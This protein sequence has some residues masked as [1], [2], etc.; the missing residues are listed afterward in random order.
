MQGIN[1]KI[2]L[3]DMSTSSICVR[4]CITSVSQ[5]CLNESL[6]ELLQSS[7][8]KTSVHGYYYTMTVQCHCILMKTGSLQVYEGESA[9][10]LFC[11]P[12]N[13]KDF[14]TISHIMFMFIVANIHYHQ[15][16]VLGLFKVMYSVTIS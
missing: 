5:L 13:A 9:I 16:V 1:I 7:E 11:C 2:I 4:T 3:L 6:H 10:E 8:D 14:P 15:I 12:S